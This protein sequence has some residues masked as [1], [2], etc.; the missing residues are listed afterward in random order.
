[1]DLWKLSQVCTAPVRAIAAE[2]EYKAEKHEVTTDDGYILT[3]YRIPPGKNCAKKTPLLLVHGLLLSA[4]C[5]VDSGLDAPGFL[6]AQEC[7]DVW[8]GN[9]RG[10][11]HSR[12][13]VTLDPDRDLKFW[14]FSVDEMGQYDV[15]AMID[16]VLDATSVKKLIYIGYSQGGGSFFIMNSEKPE[17]ADKISLFIGLAA[18]TRQ[19]YTKSVPYRSLVNAI[20]SLQSPLEASGVWEVAS[21][22]L[23]IQGTLETLCKV[24]LLAVFC[25]LGVSAVDSPHP[26]SITS[27]T[28]RRMFEHVPAGTSIQ[29]LARYGQ[30]MNEIRFVKFNYGFEENLEVYGVAE[31]PEYD[32]GMTTMPVVLFHGKSDHLVDTR[33]MDWVARQLPNVLEYVT[34]AD[35]LWN[36]FDMAFSQYWKDQ[37]FLTMKTY[38]NRYVNSY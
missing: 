11:F 33:D 12:R 5:F 20:D 24:K 30:A 7:Y 37:I 26:G 13:H 1:M 10:N 16:Y 29:N 36:H 6:L 23:P 8:F 35:P 15:P 34:V 28:T 27:K 32:L 38:L 25:N 31:P 4:E 21:R 17:Y 22:G 18:A 3:M 19:Y 14:K 2:N 9:V